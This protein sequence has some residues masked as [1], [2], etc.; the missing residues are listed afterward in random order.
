MPN[1]AG[2][3]AALKH[4]LEKELAGAQDI[5][6]SV[7]AELAKTR[8]ENRKLKADF[9]ELQ[10]KFTTTDLACT[11]SLTQFAKLKRECEDIKAERDSL[12]N[13]IDHLLDEIDV[14][15][16][17]LGTQETNVET[18][19]KLAE[20]L[21]QDI[22]KYKKRQEE[23]SEK[24]RIAVLRM[25]S[26][27]AKDVE[28]LSKEYEGKEAELRAMIRQ[29]ESSRQQSDQEWISREARLERTVKEELKAKNEELHK[30]RS[31]I[32]QLLR[33]QI[34]SMRTRVDG[35]RAHEKPRGSLTAGPAGTTTSTGVQKRSLRPAAD[36]NQ[37]TVD[38]LNSVSAG[39][40]ILSL[41]VLAKSDDFRSPVYWKGK[42]PV[43]LSDPSIMH[44]GVKLSIDNAV[45]QTIPRAARPSLSTTL[46]TGQDQQWIFGTPGGGEVSIALRL[47]PPG[48]PY[49]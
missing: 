11:K 45:L 25:E 48:K 24:H 37:Q 38:A 22:V 19:K 15:K 17:N 23:T 16:E 27:M 34:D 20:K 44:V 13:E 3:Y 28:E 46:R 2:D 31:R 21:Q 5:T 39:K 4:E 14:L 47:I 12:Y 41:E 42:Q 35:P 32:E 33:E 10:K 36:V 40:K 18:L 29:S 9:E 8:E 43:H 30:L 6:A 7:G 49:P 26:E 1:E